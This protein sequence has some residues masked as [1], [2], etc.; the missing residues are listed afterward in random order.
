[1]IRRIDDR[2]AAAIRRTDDRDT[3]RVGVLLPLEKLDS[4]SDIAEHRLH[5]RIGP[6]CCHGT[7]IGLLRRLPKSPTVDREHSESFRLHPPCE[8]IVRV[9]IALP[10]MEKK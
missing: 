8:F 6:T 9:S 1:M 7:S 2:E 5:I 4:R 3:V 10:L